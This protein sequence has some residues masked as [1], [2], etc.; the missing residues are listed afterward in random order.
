MRVD[1]YAEC[2]AVTGELYREVL[3]DIAKTASKASTG[4]GKS[5]GGCAVM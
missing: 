3:E 5:E 1:K 2:S 4:E